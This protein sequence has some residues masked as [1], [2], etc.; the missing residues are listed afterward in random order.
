M[1]TSWSVAL[2]PAVH[3]S[4]RVFPLSVDIRFEAA[5]GKQDVFGGGGGGGD[6]DGGVGAVGTVGIVAVSSPLA[7]PAASRRTSTIGRSPMRLTAHS[8][9]STGATA[10]PPRT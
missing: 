3:V 1:W 4:V 5:P 10:V 7:H 9:S 8:W 2:A 6:P